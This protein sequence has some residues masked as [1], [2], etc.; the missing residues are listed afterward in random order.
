MAT[1]TLKRKGRCHDCGAILQPGTRARWYRSGAVFGLTC[2]GTGKSTPYAGDGK[3]RAS[4]ED[5]PCSDMGYEDQ[6]AAACGE[7]L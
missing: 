1:I 6:C 7:G 5:Y 3:T 4:A 2:H